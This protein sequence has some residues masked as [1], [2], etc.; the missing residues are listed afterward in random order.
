[1][2]KDTK[3]SSSRDPEFDPHIPFVVDGTIVNRTAEARRWARAW[4]AKAKD[5][6]DFVLCTEWASDFVVAELEAKVQA[7]DPLRAFARTGT[8]ETCKN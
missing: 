8:A 4:K 1:M 7:L 5:E 6:R 3:T 2:N